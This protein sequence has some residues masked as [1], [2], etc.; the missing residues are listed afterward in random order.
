MPNLFSGTI[1]GHCGKDATTRYTQDG[2]QV[3]SVNVA[4]SFKQRDEETTAWFKVE[5]WAKSAEYLASAHKGDLL[6]AAGR[7]TLDAWTDNSGVKQ[8]TWTLHADSITILARKEPQ[9]SPAAVAAQDTY[10]IGSTTPN[11]LEGD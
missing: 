7:L 11:P 10:D 6:A 4:V 1:I 3:T 2:K 9:H 5:A 8:T